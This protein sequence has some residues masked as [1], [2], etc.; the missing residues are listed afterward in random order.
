MIGHLGKHFTFCERNSLFKRQCSQL[1]NLSTAL[2]YVVDSEL[3]SNLRK[4]TKS[5]K[6]NA[7]PR[8]C[9]Y[10]HWI[11]CVNDSK[12]I[13]RRNGLIPTTKKLDTIKEIL[14]GLGVM[15]E[16]FCA[17]NKADTKN[18]CTK[19]A[20]SMFGSKAA[21]VSTVNGRVLESIKIYSNK[22]SVLGFLK[23]FHAYAIKM[24]KRDDT[25]FLAG[26]AYHGCKTPGVH[27]RHSLWLVWDWKIYGKSL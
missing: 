16:H 23:L 26:G 11:N 13:I 6:D 10:A 7:H 20:K 15:V 2:L 21:F 18:D 27:P 9:E 19:I 5:K 8:Q 22:R 24:I 17:Q 12:D 25:P 14:P 1:M 3:A 4:V